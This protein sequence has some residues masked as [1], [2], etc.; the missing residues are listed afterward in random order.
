MSQREV[1]YSCGL[2][3]YALKLS[4]SNRTTLRIQS[5]F[6]GISKKESIVFVA[7]DESRFKQVEE[8]KCGPYYDGKESWGINRV[9]T[10]LLCGQCDAVIGYCYETFSVSPDQKSP[11]PVT[12]K[13]VVRI[14]ALQPDHDSAEASQP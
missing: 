12:R 4:S 7:I 3:G 5:R 1:S 8:V 14:K 11:P 2:C 9:R 13:I 6:L 10:K